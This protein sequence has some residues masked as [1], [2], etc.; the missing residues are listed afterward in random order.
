MEELVQDL[1]SALEESELKIEVDHE[2]PQHE[3][4]RKRRIRKRRPMPTDASSIYTCT[5][6]WSDE[7][8]TNVKSAV[9]VVCERRLSGSDTESGFLLPVTKVRRHRRKKSKKMET[10]TNSTKLLKCKMDCNSNSTTAPYMDHKQDIESGIS[11]SDESNGDISA[12][13]GDDEMTD[14]YSEPGGS[15]CGVPSII[16]WWEEETIDETKLRCII[17]GAMPHLSETAQKGFHSRINRLPGMAARSIRRGRRRY[18]QKKPGER[19][20]NNAEAPRQEMKNYKRRKTEGFMET[21]LAA[22]P[23]IPLPNT[24]KGHKMLVS[25]GWSPGEGLGIN[26]HGMQNPVLATRR[27]KRRGFGS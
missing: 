12:Q 21:E 24:N 6:T 14:F 27:Q 22:V 23:S 18:K 11:G 25:M 26:G 13:D 17:N 15:V 3:L 16:P 8:S 9:S 5:E 4:F 20:F 10:E 1:T 2:S 7:S 19:V